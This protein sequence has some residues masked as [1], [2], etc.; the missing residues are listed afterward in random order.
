MPPYIHSSVWHHIPR[1]LHATMKW[2]GYSAF[3]ITKHKKEESALGRCVCGE[4]GRGVITRLI[5]NKSHTLLLSVF[6]LDINYLMQ[7][8]VGLNTLQVM[9]LTINLEFI[10]KYMKQSPL[11]YLIQ[12]SLVVVVCYLIVPSSSDNPV[13]TSVNEAAS[14]ILHENACHW[15]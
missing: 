12:Y 10:W 11:F 5:V 14:L 9:S 2:S 3:I 8:A 7:S 4:G 13:L 6:F 15:I 1:L